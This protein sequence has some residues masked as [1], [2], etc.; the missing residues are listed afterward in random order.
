[1]SVSLRGLAPGLM[2]KGAKAVSTTMSQFSRQAHNQAVAHGKREGDISDSFASLAGLKAEP[3]PQQFLDLKR[4][5]VRGHEDAIISSWNQILH[6]LKIENEIVA[7][8]GPNAV[9]SI[10]FDALDSQMAVLR[11]EIKKRGVAVIRGVIAEDEARQ[12]KNEL[13]AYVKQNPSTRGDC[14]FRNSLKSF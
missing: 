6:Q 4:S 14:Q 12:Y 8:E 13:E 7:R 11:S 1:M 2:Q 3:L 9:P 10:E 5:L